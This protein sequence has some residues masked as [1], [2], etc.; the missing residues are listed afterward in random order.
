MAHET[1]AK[2]L[3]AD[4]SAPAFVGTWQNRA[5]GL[6][7]SSVIAVI[8]AWLGQAQQAWA[9][10]ICCVAGCWASWSPLDLPWAA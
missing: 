4:L 7:I 5:L 6:V 10:T 2:T 3:P 1:Q 9:G 8:L